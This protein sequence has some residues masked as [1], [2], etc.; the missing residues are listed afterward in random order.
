LYFIR[1]I[2]FIFVTTALLS[3][4]TSIDEVVSAIKVGD[5]NRISR[6]F[7]NMVEISLNDKRHAYSKSQAEMI[8]RDFF[9]NKGV[10]SFKVVHRGNSNDTEYCVG[11]LAT[12]SGNYRTTVFMKVKGDRKVIKELIFEEDS[13]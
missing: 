6:Y 12:E 5:A 8:V 10:K 7:D 11:N 2:L 13:K 9:S 4:G 1:T 3:F